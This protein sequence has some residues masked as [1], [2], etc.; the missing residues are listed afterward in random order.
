VFGCNGN[1][2]GALQIAT[3]S[4]QLTLGNLTLTN[5]ITGILLNN[6]TTTTATIP[7]STFI[8]NT[9]GVHLLGS[10]A[11]TLTGATFTGNS[12]GVWAESGT[13]S[14]TG[15]TFTDNTKGVLGQSGAATISGGS[16]T[17]SAGKVQTFLSAAAFRTAY[18]G[19]TVSGGGMAVA[20]IQPGTMSGANIWGQTGMIYVLDTGG[21]T[22]PATGSLTISPG[23]VVKFKPNTGCS[24]S[25][26]Q[27]NGS[28]T[29]NGT[30]SQPIVF[31]S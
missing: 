14:I 21:L 12:N 30:A 17:T 8:G 18:S 4:A 15:S 31:T 1:E 9:N 16:I 10:S 20:E 23:L 24:P 6:G 13:A 5:N 7:G 11:A 27:I 22:L 28:L 2:V 26:L 3:Q 19:A 25:F 29:A